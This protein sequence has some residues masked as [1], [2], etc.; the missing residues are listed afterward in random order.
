MERNSCFGLDACLLSLV[1]LKD[2]NA[3]SINQ[4]VYCNHYNGSVE[5]RCRVLRPM[6][7]LA[8]ALVSLFDKRP[9]FAWSYY[10]IFFLNAQ[11][12]R[13]AKTISCRIYEVSRQRDACA[14]RCRPWTNPP[15]IAMA[16][17]F[18][19][20]IDNC[21]HLRFP[22]KRLQLNRIKSKWVFGH[23]RPVANLMRLR[24][25]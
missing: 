3:F 15:C 25:C 18:S 5:R 22:E 7:L 24:T 12:R 20:L 17:V 6:K 16:E 19:W 11:V 4:C 8:A 23:V 13:N 9:H 14:E 1:T 21:T 10:A 2:T